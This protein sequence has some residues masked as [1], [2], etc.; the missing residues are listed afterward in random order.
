VVGIVAVVEYEAKKPDRPDPVGRAAK[1]AALG[2]V[3][4][5]LNARRKA[6]LALFEAKRCG[7]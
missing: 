7:K 4:D 6:A 2:R 3:L 1:D 5:E